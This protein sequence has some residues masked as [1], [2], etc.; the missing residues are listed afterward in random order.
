MAFTSPSLT[1]PKPQVVPG[2]KYLAAQ[3]GVGSWKKR[4][5]VGECLMSYRR[6]NNACSGDCV[7]MESV[8]L[9]QAK[10]HSSTKMRL[11]SHDCWYCDRIH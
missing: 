7:Q 2:P 8:T 5:H 6:Q 9:N 10:T 1:I 11:K 3:C 4:R